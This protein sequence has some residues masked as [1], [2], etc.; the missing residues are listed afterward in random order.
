[1]KQD[2]AQLPKDIL[3]LFDNP[4]PPPRLDLE[5]PLNTDWFLEMEKR[6]NISEEK[7]DE[8]LKSLEEPEAKVGDDGKFID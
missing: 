7:L 4:R 3:E 2:K 5:N 8:F 6:C 1:M